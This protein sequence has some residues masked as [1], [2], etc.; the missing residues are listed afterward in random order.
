M[1]RS[2]H[3]GKFPLVVSL[4]PLLEGE[5]KT[6]LVRLS[7]AQGARCVVWPNRQ[8]TAEEREAF[9]H[10]ILQSE[11]RTSLAH[12]LRAVAMEQPGLWSVAGT[13]WK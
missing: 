11:E 3:V 2:L 12:R 5:L 9:V 7:L 4:G 1:R 8:L 10:A 13:P 6:D